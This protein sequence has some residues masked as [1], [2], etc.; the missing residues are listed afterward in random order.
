MLLAQY[1]EKIAD[2]QKLLDDLPEMA[3]DAGIA[4]AQ[5]LADAISPISEFVYNQ[6]CGVIDGDHVA[7]SRIL[8]MFGRT[9]YMARNDTF[10]TLANMPAWGMTTLLATMPRFAELSAKFRDRDCRPMPGYEEKNINNWPEQDKKEFFE[11]H[12]HHQVLAA[13]F[14]TPGSDTIIFDNKVY[15]WA[16][17]QV[18]VLP[19]RDVSEIC[20]DAVS[21]PEPVPVT[22]SSV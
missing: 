22:Y 13:W 8:R 17:P 5:A 19:V 9:Y 7:V 2:M 10:L 15:Y 12:F 18:R 20:N 4:S 6:G 1:R 16:D 14:M 3:D 11:F 21:S